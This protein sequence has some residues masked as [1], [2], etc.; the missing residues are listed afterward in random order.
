MYEVNPDIDFVANSVDNIKDELGEALL[1]AWQ[2]IPQCDGEE[3]TGRYEYR[4]VVLHF[5]ELAPWILS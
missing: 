3:A 1:R 5:L 4:A 2:L